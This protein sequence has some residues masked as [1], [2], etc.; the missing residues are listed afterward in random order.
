[1]L[2]GCYTNEFYVYL[3]P[4]TPL[5]LLGIDYQLGVGRT[6]L[7]YLIC[8]QGPETRTGFVVMEMIPNWFSLVSI[9][10]IYLPRE[11]RNVSVIIDLVSKTV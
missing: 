3:S 6:N 10:G 11:V 1:M 9:V 7:L 5:E 2:L 4:L 8:L